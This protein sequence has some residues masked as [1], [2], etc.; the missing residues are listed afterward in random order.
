[1]SKPAYKLKGKD[2]FP[3]RGLMGY[4]KRTSN[5]SYDEVPNFLSVGARE[6]LVYLG[7]VAFFGSLFIGALEGLERLV[8]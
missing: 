1:M 4:H 3:I 5:L 2:S 8:S 7:N 6:F